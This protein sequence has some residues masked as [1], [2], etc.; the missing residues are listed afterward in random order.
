MENIVA[1]D[2]VRTVNEL[3]RRGRLA[4]DDWHKNIRRWRRLYEMEHYETPAAEGEMRY[5]DPTPTNTVDLSVGIMM[6]NPVEFRATGWNPGP[7]EMTDTGRIEKL[8]SALVGINS[9]REEVRLEYEINLHF[10]R[11]G[12]G[13]LYGVWDPDLAMQAWDWI[14]RS[15]PTTG[16]VS[17]V[18]IFKEPPIRTQVI[19]PLEIFLV[20]GG[21]KR[22]QAVVRVTR[23]PIADVE[24]LYNVTIQRAL[25]ANLETKR[26]TEGELKDAWWF[27][28]KA[29][30]MIGPDG[31]PLMNAVL[32]RPEEVQRYVVRNAVLFDDQA[33]WESRDMTGYSDLPMTIGFF[34][35]VLRDKAEG[36]GDS[37]IEPMAGTVR[38]METMINRRTRQ[39]NMYT[40]L[41]IVTKTQTG[42]PVK[43][44]AVFGKPVALGMNET[45]ELPQWPGNPP[46]VEMHINYLR[47]RLQQ[48]GFSDLM[49][50]TSMGAGSGYAI[51]QLGDQNRIRLA[52]PAT[53][54]ELLW[55]LWARK[56]LDLVTFFAKGTVMR[57]SGRLRGKDFAEQIVGESMN[58]YTV[59]AI[60]RPRFPN[61]ETREVAMSTQVKGTLPL[62]YI[63]ERF[64]HVEQADDA[65]EQF[66]LEQAQRHPAMMEYGVR[67]F[68]MEMTQSDDEVQAAAAAMTLE[69][70]QMNAIGGQPGRPTEPTR[71]EQLLSTPSPTGQAT[72]QERG[73]QPAGQSEIDQLTRMVTE[74]PGLGQ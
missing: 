42:R 10:V 39:V 73:G 41:P 12:C 37:I 2:T 67:T 49:F 31:Q 43:I 30:P 32:G 28:K 17:H 4:S 61:D 3:L 16:E 11:D 25:G 55:T 33:I 9:E 13:I 7:Q 70:M 19:D 23:M 47:A 45:F 21:H 46:D 40:A 66:I 22:W 63:Y 20:P 14:S 57:I 74:V 36:W 27:E 48:A 18:G 68:L 5:D 1:S 35:P 8:L 69:A 60:I 34:K 59:R 15:D 65:Y 52:Q 58:Q 50:S 38:L 54:L 26:T 56:V 53:H 24:N 51:S 71:P 64:L 72:S 44:D 6:A 62:R 29:V